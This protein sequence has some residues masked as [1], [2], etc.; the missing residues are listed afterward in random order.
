MVYRF[1]W[2]A[3]LTAFWFAFT[4]LN[5]LLRPTTEGVTWQL[6]VISALILGVAV[7]WFGLALRLPTWI[8]VLLNGLGLMIAITR[9]AA[10][11]TSRFL[12]PTFE[13]FAELEEQLRE[14]ARIIRS[15][16]EPVLPLTGVV[17]VVM[18]VFWISGMILAWGLMRSHPYAALIPPLV[19]TLQFATMNRGPSPLLEIAMFVA[20]VAITILAIA[21]DERSH[22]VGRMAPRGTWPASRTSPPA[23][24]I[25]LLGVTVVAALVSVQAFQSFA[26]PDGW[27]NWR[28]EQGIGDDFYGS[29]EYNPFVS[30]QQRLVRPSDT[31]VF[32]ASISG[33]V[34]GDQVY[35][36][37][38]TMDAYNGTQFFAVEGEVESTDEF[39]YE[40]PAATFAGPTANI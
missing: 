38:L 27:L 23:S 22:T 14:A 10:P 25:G 8:V 30:I 4:Q 3:G 37:F 28:D 17:I 11:G 24:S 39:P 16:I 20:L 33:D 5:G 6:A 35:F 26:P 18:V 13:T 15:A 34:P 40:D 19:L 32:Q 31:P 1:S 7:T 12:M 21:T 36:Q 2:L 9:I 29:I